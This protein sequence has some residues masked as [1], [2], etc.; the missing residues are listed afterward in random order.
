MFKFKSLQVGSLCEGGIALRTV[1]ELLS[2]GG[3]AMQFSQRV[4]EEP[5]LVALIIASGTGVGAPPS[6]GLWG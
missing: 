6:Q 2:A 3:I 5:T 1:V 4:E